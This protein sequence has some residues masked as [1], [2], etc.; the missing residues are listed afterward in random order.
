MYRCTRFSPV[1]L[2]IPMQSPWNQS[3][4]LSHAI[5]NLWLSGPRQMQ[6]GPLSD[7]L[8]SSLSPPSCSSSSSRS[9]TGP[10]SEPAVD[11]GSFFLPPPPPGLVRVPPGPAA[12]PVLAGRFGP[13]TVVA[14]PFFLGLAGTL[15]A[16]ESPATELVSLAL[17]AA[18]LCCELIAGSPS[19]VSSSIFGY[20][21]VIFF[22]FL[23]WKTE[24]CLTRDSDGLQE[25]QARF[26]VSVKGSS[27]EP[28]VT[29]HVC[30][31]ACIKVK[32]VRGREREERRNKMPSVS[33]SEQFLCEI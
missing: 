27:G 4:H 18:L 12:A 30:D 9:G 13:L 15:P 1:Y 32:K 16:V 25:S 14:V 26:V 8:P 3:S 6:Y 20:Y 17:V 21:C 24:A 10:A 22:S 5:M 29:R 11:A 28:S 31:S 33:L 2:S 19:D 7:S 23:F